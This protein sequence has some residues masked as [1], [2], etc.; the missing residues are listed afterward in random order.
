[1]KMVRSRTGCAP[2]WAAALAVG[3][4]VSARELRA[5]EPHCHCPATAATE[6]V[7]LL[8]KIPYVGRLFKTTPCDESCQRI[9][10]DFAGG[11]QGPK[12]MF[13]IG[14]QS[15]S[16]ECTCD[17]CKCPAGTC[18]ANCVKAD[19]CVCTN[20]P[21][22]EGSCPEAC[23]A[24]VAHSHCCAQQCAEKCAAGSH[25][26][27]VQTAEGC[28]AGKCCIVRVTADE[29]CPTAIVANCQAECA[30]HCVAGKC[31]PADV[32][33]FHLPAPDRLVDVS[34]LSA[35][36]IR[37]ASQ[38]E[39]QESIF[40]ERSELLDAMA[41]LSAEKAKLE[42]CLEFQ[43]QHAELVKEM[44]ELYAENLRLKA[45]ADL[46][47]ERESLL[48]EG[49]K[50]ALENE[51]LK[52]QVAELERRLETEAARTAKS[53]YADSTQTAR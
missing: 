19:N 42:A 23:V 17:D 24:H 41:E 36:N 43:A 21:C 28:A 37:L 29:A 49:L 40:E 44:H 7:P 27:A 10:I 5:D 20:C 18:P 11:Q 1:M 22:P 4:V 53:P 45:Q 31:L 15:A 47:T 14:W 50:T 25:C 12:L 2:A 8:T 48:R 3:L 6:C 33:V 16:A 32:R 26:C 34:R 46:A 38:L 13:G 51:R 9:G 52:L 30:D 35:E 39:A